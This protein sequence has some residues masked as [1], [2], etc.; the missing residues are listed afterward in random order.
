MKVRG[1]CCYCLHSL[2]MVLPTYL[3]L[4]ILRTDVV[5]PNLKKKNMVSHLFNYIKENSME[6][7]ES[8]FLT[9]EQK[10]T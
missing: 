1:Q 8:S 7:L 5:P 10:V 3:A 9:S 4:R 2:Q 6:K